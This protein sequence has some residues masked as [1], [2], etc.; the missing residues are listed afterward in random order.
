VGQVK[1][2][3]SQEIY[4]RGELDNSSKPN[5]TR[6]KGSPPEKHFTAIRKSYSLFLGLTLK[7]GVVDD[8]DNDDE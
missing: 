2:L 5:R 8:D 4:S 3:L 1:G 6:T 7:K